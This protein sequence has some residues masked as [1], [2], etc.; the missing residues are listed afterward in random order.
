MVS[1][2][3]EL[4]HSMRPLTWTIVVANVEKGALFMERL[5]AIPVILDL[6]PVMENNS[7]T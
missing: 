3:K 2:C 5:C 1:V 4:S 6:I 7:A